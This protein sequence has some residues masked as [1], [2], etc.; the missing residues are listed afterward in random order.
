MSALLKFLITP[1]D[2]ILNKDRLLLNHQND[3][4]MDIQ[5][6]LNNAKNMLDNIP[7]TDF[8]YISR[9][10]DVYKTIKQQLYYKYHVQIVTNATLK[11]YEIITQMNIIKK[12]KITAFCNAE[13]PGGFIIGIN[14]YLKTMFTN[15]KFNWVANSFIDINKLGDTYGIYKHN[16]HNWVM[17]NDMNGDI[18]DKENIY[19]I[20][21]KVL[22][23]FP[24]G[25]DIY[26]SD[27]GF[28]VSSDYNSQEQQTLL[29]NYCQILCGLLTLQKGGSLITKQFTYFTIFNRSLITLLST[30]FNLYIVKPATSRPLNSEIYLVGTLYKGI[31]K[32]MRDYLINLLDN[33]DPNIPIILY[34]PNTDLLLSAEH[35]YEHQQISC[36]NYM[37]QV[38]KNKIHINQNTH[39]K[40]QDDWLKANPF[41][42]INVNDYVKSNQNL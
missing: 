28:D 20:I 40:I 24:N 9:H 32:D 37:Y 16:P 34:N 41:K 8:S 6:K 29:L 13:L 38:Y 2:I 18:T 30:L 35:I 19:K 3:D 25:V 33:I 15:A 7:E 26:T 12:N 36:I 21:D 10:L 1:V 31:T 14:H 42:L 17:S 39:K 23:R 5:K 27:A 22:A 11:I 4:F